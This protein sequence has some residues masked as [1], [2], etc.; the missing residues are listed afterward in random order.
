MY[1][2]RKRKKTGALL[3]RRNIGLRDCMGTDMLTMMTRKQRETYI[4]LMK[5]SNLLSSNHQILNQQALLLSPLSQTTDV[6][7]LL[8]M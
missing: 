2:C 7:S 3:N 1:L 8:F 6:L 4:S 5:I